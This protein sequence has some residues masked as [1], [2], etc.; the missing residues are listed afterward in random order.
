MQAQ[1]RTTLSESLK[2]VVSQT[3]F[4]RKGGGRIC[5]LEVL[6]Q[7]PAVSAL[8]REGKT[9][10]LINII[11]TNRRMGMRM[12]DDHIEELLDDSLISEEEAFDKCIDKKR[13]IKY[14]KEIPQEYKEMFKM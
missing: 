14:L 12:L 7:T 5:A 8:V 13:F 1:I 10:Q 11:Q 9:H 4:K 2:A 6:I 3:L